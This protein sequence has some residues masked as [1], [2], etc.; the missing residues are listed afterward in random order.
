MVH[1]KL[2]QPEGFEVDLYGSAVMENEAGEVAQISFGMDNAYQCQLE[3]WGSKA[4]LLAP[5]VFTAGAGMRPTLILRTSAE[6][7][8]I[9]LEP[10]DQFLRSI[11]RFV[12]RV[13]A[14]EKIDSTVMRIKRHSAIMT[15]MLQ[16]E[17]LK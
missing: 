7:N 12:S 9:D 17:D 13:N 14:E 15:E 1:S 2:V 8:K 11:Q 6:E 3:V 10:D 4:T 5:R 16:G